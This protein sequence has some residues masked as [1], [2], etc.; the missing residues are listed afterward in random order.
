MRKIFLLTVLLINCCLVFSQTKKPIL[1]GDYIMIPNSGGRFTLKTDSSKYLRYDGYEV[2]DIRKAT[3]IQLQKIKER[4]RIVNLQKDRFWGLTILSDRYPLPRQSLGLRFEKNTGAKIFEGNK[5]QWGT[6]YK[7]TI[8]ING[9]SNVEII[10]GLINENNAKNYRYRVVQNDN[11]ELIGW[12]TPSIF[13]KTTD[14]S[15]AYCF[16]SN[17][18]YQKNQFITIE[19]YNVNNYKDRD[20]ILIDWREPKQLDLSARIGYHH[21][22]Y[23]NALLSVLLLG[24]GTKFRQNFVVSDTVDNVKIRLGDSLI[25]MGFDARNNNPSYN[26]SVDF[27]KVNENELINLGET[28]G[29]FL[30]YKEYWNKPGD[31]QITFTPKLSSVGG[32]SITYLNDKVFTYRFTVLPDLH[33][34]LVLSQREA[35]LIG[36]IAFPVLVLLIILMVYLIRKKGRKRLLLAQKQKEISKMQLSSIRSQ[37]NPHFMFNALAGI[38]NL[39]NT[40]K[41]D[42]A[43]SYLGKFARLTRNVLDQQEAISLAEERDLLADYLQ[44]EQLRFG[45]NFIINID[46]TLDLNNVEIPVMLLQPFLENAVKHGVA[47]KENEGKIEIL[48]NKQAE[49]LII[50]IKDNGQGFDSDKTYNG[51]G[52][53]LSKNRISLLNNIYTAT[54]F[55]LKI[56]SNNEG[57]TITIILTQWL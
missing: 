4:E 8:I 56:D 12:T 50:E 29:S 35:L 28:N 20:A 34:K 31:Y 2:V 24:K 41:I 40:N 21:K 42:E 14:K 5:W 43:N 22:K 44:M 16:L 13:K 9:K 47:S 52:L 3:V 38:Q 33:P 11:K 32:K 27:K 46:Q 17:I 15:A 18:I 57:T 10:D 54:P 26:Y 48:F 30:L 6:R 36:L 1:K 45:F 23:G 53:Q 55:V 39:M 37:L 7:N 51:L 25:L 49:D 19:I